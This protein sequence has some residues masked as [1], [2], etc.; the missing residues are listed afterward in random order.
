MARQ[1]IGF[2]FVVCSDCG[3]EVDRIEYDEGASSPAVES[4]AT[5]LGL[6]VDE[7]TK[8]VKRTNPGAEL[9]SEQRARQL[10]SSIASGDAAGNDAKCPNGHDGLSVTD[11]PPTPAVAV[12]IVKG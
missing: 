2:V 4:V 3:A 1:Q 9:T 11:E 12:Q 6:G 8:L 5:A 7:A 10:A